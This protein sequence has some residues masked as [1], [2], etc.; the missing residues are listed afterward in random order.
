MLGDPATALALGLILTMTASPHLL[1][2]DALLLTIPLAWL[3]RSEWGP[4]L[5]LALLM[6]AAT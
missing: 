3:A 1:A 4:A 2:Y 5:A 6:S